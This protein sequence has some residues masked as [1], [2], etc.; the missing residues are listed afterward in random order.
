MSRSRRTLI[1]LGA[2]AGI[3]VG[4]AHRS[5]G[6]VE[7]AGRQQLVAARP[8]APVDAAE[9]CE[10][11][12]RMTRPHTG[13]R[14]AVVVAAGAF[15]PEAAGRGDALTAAALHRAPAFCRVV[16]TLTPVAGSAIGAE[17]W[18]PLAGW[19][20]KLQSVG[21]R[22]WGGAISHPALATALAAGYAAASTDTGH[23]GGGAA[24][25]LGGREPMVDAGYRAVHETTLLAKEVVHRY[26]GEDARRSYWNGCSLGGR[27][28][29]AEA[30]RYPS[31]Y[32]GIVVGDPANNLIDLYAA[33][34]IQA[35][36]AHRTPSSGVGPR[37]LTALHD[38]VLE[39][40]DRLDRVGDGVIE[41]P[42]QCHV[43]PARLECGRPG[44]DAGACLQP[45][46]VETVRRLYAPVTHPVTGGTLSDGLQP[47]SELGWSAVAGAEPET[48]ALGL[49]RFVV[50]S[51]PSW[52]WRDR[53]FPA[54]VDR[55]RAAWSGL[56]DAVSPALAPFTGRGGKLL[57]YHGWSDPQTPP[58]NTIAYY[59]R[60]RDT[61]GA[62]AD[63]SVRLFMVPGMGHCEGG[64]GTDTFD[65]VAALD[66]WVSA[67]V[68]PEMMPA[69]RRVGGVVTK[70][71]PLCAW[72]SVASWD[73]R[74]HTDRAESFTC[75][76]AT[77]DLSG[78][79]HE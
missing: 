57:M 23:R 8:A 54:H 19:N 65:R 42:L 2:A 40:C 6:D 14:L 43:D 77:A 31:D 51:D 71:R 50:L 20:G 9:R 21:N 16:V 66:E 32:D 7:A 22:G 18:L 69:T 15:T 35:R 5:G 73:G 47:G 37:L 74:G 78:R 45:E 75:R 34:L 1:A 33:R 56:L 72:G 25:A 64:A 53:E 62:S 38:A 48:N 79:L 70:S 28:G 49:F 29:L 60:V 52:D 11:L 61:L 26:Y 46:Q 44:V 13:V 4:I 41:N 63:A 27:Q 55:A 30:Q 3:A 36:V 59:Q 10:A 68:A 39:A 17:V 67:G 58:G 12:S 76:P 24:F